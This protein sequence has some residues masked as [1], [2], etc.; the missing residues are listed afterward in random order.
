MPAKHM[1]PYKLLPVIIPSG[2]LCLAA[3]GSA[4]A[5]SNI[6]MLPLLQN[7]GLA[8]SVLLASLPYVEWPDTTCMHYA[9]AGIHQDLVPL[10]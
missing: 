10:E 2:P 8:A 6:L 4:P 9:H 5:Q 7:S 1:R 3:V